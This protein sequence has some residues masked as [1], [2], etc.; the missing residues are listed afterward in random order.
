MNH[1]L[2]ILVC[3]HFKNELAAVIA[4]E[5]L[6]NVKLA[7][8]PARCSRPPLGWN[9]LERAFNDCGDCQTALVSGGCCITKLEAAPEKQHIFSLHK[10]ELCAYM[11]AGKTVIDRY[12]S[13]GAYLVT[14]GWLADWRLHI[15]NLGFTRAL[16]RQFFAESTRHLLLLDTQ[17]DKES[18]GHL[19]R[20]SEYIDRPY[21][22]R[23]IGLDYVRLFITKLVFQ[24]QLENNKKYTAQ[25][26]RNTDQKISEYE[27]L[28][29][30]LTTIVQSINID[31]TIRQVID[32]FKMLFAPD[33]ISYQPFDKNRPKEVPQLS[34]EC[35]A[36]IDAP[37]I[38]LQ[39]NCREWV[40]TSSGNGFLLKIHHKDQVYG[41]LTVDGLMLPEH[42]EHY[43][44]LALKI[45]E[46]CGL[47]INHAYIFEKIRDTNRLLE[48][49]E[50]KFRML[51]S[52]SPTGIYQTDEKGDSNYVNPKWCDIAGLSPEEAHGK[53]WLKAIHPEDRDAVRSSWQKMVA[54]KGQW[55]QEYRFQTPDGKTTWVH[56]LARAIHM[57]NGEISGY[58]GTN[59][60]I[61]ERKRAREAL[62][63]AKEE[64]EAASRAKSI[65]IANM[66][67]E[68][69]TPMNAVMGFSNLLSSIITD[70]KQKSYLQSIQLSGRNLLKLIN[71]ILDLS[72]IE[73]GKLEVQYEA[74]N[75]KAVFNE[76]KQIFQA[77]ISE[78][79]LE[80]IL[81]MDEAIPKALMLDETRLRQ[82]LLNLV[83]N[84]IKF[85]D[86]GHVKL[87]AKIT[88]PEKNHSKLDLV[89][90][91]EDTGIGI[92]QN[93]ILSIFESF[94][95]QDGQS[96]REYGG[97]G[98]GL[99]ISK[100]L[101][102]MM[103][104]E[105]S[106]QSTPGKGSIFEVILRGIEVS[107]TGA[108]RLRSDT[109]FDITNISFDPSL[110]L[111]V[112][113]IQS[114]RELIKESLT[115]TGLKILEA[116]NG[117]QAIR[118]A[119]EFLPDV[120]LMDIKMPVMN[121][122][123]AAKMLKANPVTSDIPVI[124]VT[125]SVGMEEFKN[126]KE[127]GFDGY[128][129]K[130]VDMHDLFNELFQFLKYSKKEKKTIISNTNDCSPETIPL[131]DI[132]N[133]TEF[134]SKLESTLMPAWEDLKGAMDM[135]AIQKF[136]RQLY[137]IS[138]NHQCYSLQEY[139]IR[140]L[141]YTVAF[142]VEKIDR[143]IN[144]F[145]DMI[146][147]IKGEE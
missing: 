12:V 108:A 118:Q 113:D 23:E 114:N 91:I 1:K 52:M 32:I 66:S 95:Q 10:L 53:E 137:E 8:V 90:S 146:S 147:K 136:A 13:D 79:H 94:K 34:A 16:A 87:S 88:Y 70:K 97:T 28:M 46:V 9:E 106:V 72:K 128:I 31:D 123:E 84:A 144:K 121:G 20:F 35:P 126:I 48:E 41:T 77:K 60:D 42:K 11:L 141:D 67:H 133:L 18:P 68:I 26:S 33:E 51:A 64:A 80:F 107:K 45:T 6:D 75:P 125:A 14:P 62:N 47:S 22:I 134:I 73:A 4:L 112:D 40:W 98:L 111:I 99:S 3:E 116:E 122:Y 69:R 83:G 103:N 130:P 36:G 142:E 44:Q 55:G 56:G 71:D 110:V 143:S 82:V 135:D 138:D 63:L 119:T 49:S 85:T 78:K 27:M 30:L 109:F 17:I 145:P 2:C 101:A 19:I 139:A 74:V 58:I 54:S 76:I 15:N 39:D 140:L 124:A 105:I 120:I 38:Q 115:L 59:I 57:E 93:Q 102:E 50:K 127:L 100:R 104:G 81:D 29:D 92:P 43:L 7:T 131:D 25:T 37:G 132:E 129:P 24:W 21:K 5:Q 96:T 89:I 117:Q 65:F 86:T 61:T